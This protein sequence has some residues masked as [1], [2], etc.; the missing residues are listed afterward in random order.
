MNK[1]WSDKNKSFQQL[2]K[3]NTF[4]EGISTLLEL[5]EELM[6]EMLSWKKELTIEDY[7]AIPFINADGYHS[8]TI[9]Y[10]IWHI[11]RIEDIVVHTLIKK[12]EQIL[13]S[14]KYQNKINS[15]I[16]TTGN[17]LVKE[18]IADFS[19]QLD[20]D[21]L[22]KYALDVKKNT[23]KWLKTIDYSSL[24]I[25]FDENDKEAI[26]QLNV[27]STD[28]SAIWLIDYWCNKDIKGL[29]QMPLS[30]HWIMHIEAANRIKDKLEAMK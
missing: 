21:E 27:V 23:D 4:D 18:Q 26:G 3:K 12:D 29:L 6:H 22:Y 13:F 5:R 2:L 20:I 1:E 11:I 19:K 16:I 7:S 17:E 24:K 15:P 28:E 25:R 8:K 14:K 10:S 9:A 30:R